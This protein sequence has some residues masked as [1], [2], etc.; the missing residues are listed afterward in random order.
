MEGLKELRGLV[1]EIFIKCGVPKDDA[2]LGADVL[3]FA[4]ESG[5]DTHGVSNM[6]RSYVDLYNTKVL[7]PTPQLDIIKETPSTATIDGDK[8][9]GII[10]TPK[11][12]VTAAKQME[13]DGAF[14]LA[15]MMGGGEM[16]E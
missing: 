12:I 6:L 8:G 14:N 11:T 3:I 2:V 13:K 5:I 16:I 4:D 1:E 7:N 10:I 9:L 15:D